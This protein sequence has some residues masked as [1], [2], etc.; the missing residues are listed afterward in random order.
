MKKQNVM[1]GNTIEVNK[2]SV[3][4]IGKPLLQKKEIAD[5]KVK[6]VRI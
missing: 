5:R 3:V 4:K 2:T 1:D 6:R